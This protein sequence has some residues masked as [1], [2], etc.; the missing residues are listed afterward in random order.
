METGRRA[1]AASLPLHQLQRRFGFLAATQQAQ[2][3]GL[4]L[5]P[6]QGS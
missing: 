1:E 4:N 5:D 2:I 6:S 3:Q